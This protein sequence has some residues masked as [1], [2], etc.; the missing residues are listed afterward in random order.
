VRR[1]KRNR[2]CSEAGG[3]WRKLVH[4]EWDG[5]GWCCSSPEGS[6]LDG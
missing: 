5:W 3:R 6:A 4:G 1:G 2:A